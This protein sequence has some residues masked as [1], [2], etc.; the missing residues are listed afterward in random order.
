MAMLLQSYLTSFSSKVILSFSEKIIHDNN[1][2]LKKSTSFKQK[3]KAKYKG[4]YKIIFFFELF[5]FRGKLFKELI[6]LLIGLKII[7]MDSNLNLISFLFKSLKL[8][9]NTVSTFSILFNKIKSNL[10]LTKGV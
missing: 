8:L 4:I 1:I 7:L 9:S 3:M 5:S 10:S 6:L 2:Y